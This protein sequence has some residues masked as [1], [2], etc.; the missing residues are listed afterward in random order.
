MLICLPTLGR[1]KWNRVQV[2]V[3][4]K[5]Q[6]APGGLREGRRE[7]L[8]SAFRDRSEERALHRMPRAGSRKHG[9][10]LSFVCGRLHRG[11]SSTWV[12]ESPRRRPISNN[13]VRN[14]LARRHCCSYSVIVV[15]KSMHVLITKFCWIMNIWYW[16]WFRSYSQLILQQN[17][18][19]HHHHPKHKWRTLKLHS[20]KVW[21]MNRRRSFSSEWHS[22]ILRIKC[23][24]WWFHILYICDSWV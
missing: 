24:N 14:V 4:E 17:H 19:H 23:Y 9:R 2:R 7:H 18:H 10:S 15:F 20:W 22:N 8:G 16:M 13:N 1:G 3:A 5:V 21:L 11:T 6:R 12:S